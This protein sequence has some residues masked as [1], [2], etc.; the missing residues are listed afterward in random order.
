MKIPI[1]KKL[2]VED[3]PK[4]QRD[5][6]G[7][8]VQNIND[9]SDNLV[10][11]L[12]KNVDIQ[13]NLDGQVEVQQ[14]YYRQ[15]APSTFPLY[16]KNKLRKQPVACMLGKI[17]EQASQN[18]QNPPGIDANSV[19]IHWELT[20]NNLIKIRNITGLTVNDA[21]PHLYQVI[22]ILL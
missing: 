22:F 20:G 21:V 8:L 19:T 4:D 7:P 2:V 11:I 10:T 14:F 13:N 15:T 1:L 18:Y 17:S 6:I 16:F 3:F 12:D 5:G 9:I